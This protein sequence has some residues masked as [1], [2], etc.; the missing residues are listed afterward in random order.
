[1]KKIVIYFILVFL[2]GQLLAQSS[3]MRSPFQYEIA[4]NGDTINRTNK[5]GLRVGLWSIYNESRFGDDSFYETGAFTEDKKNGVWKMYSKNGLLLRATNYYNN[6]KNGEE[7]FY[8]D[9]RLFC[10]GQNKA[11]RTDV[12]YDTIMIEDPVTNKLTEKIVPTSLGSVRHG[13]WVYYKPPFNEIK[14]IEEY[15]LDELIY[16]QDYTTKSDSLA[17]KKRLAK[18]PHSSGK[19]PPGIWGVKKGKA[20]VRFTDF[21]E[22]E[23]FIKPNP[24]KKKH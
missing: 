11:L 9:G 19:L 21:K 5:N 22:N 13:F 12:A 15:Q 17:F 1:V 16:E 3:G 23:K 20:P 8:D 24:G 14:R 4:M 6:Y 2:S 18:Y 10:I 7:K